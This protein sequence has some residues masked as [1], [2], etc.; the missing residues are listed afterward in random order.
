VKL[1]CQGL[2]TNNIKFKVTSHFLI[3]ILTK[4]QFKAN[5]VWEYIRSI[6]EVIAKYLVLKIIITS[7][8][9]H[10][11]PHDGLPKN[12]PFMAELVF[13]RVPNNLQRY[14]ILQPVSQYNGKRN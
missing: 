3:I 9:N 2:I 8:K 14:E 11:N 12:F 1:R 7:E 10:K 4:W 5:K 13:N 6:K